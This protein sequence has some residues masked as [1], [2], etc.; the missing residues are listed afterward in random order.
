MLNAW[1][2]GGHVLRADRTAPVR[3]STMVLVGGT[4]QRFVV[5]LALFALG[6]GVFGLSPAPML[7]AFAFAQLAYALNRYVP[8]GT[9]S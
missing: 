1:F 2:L 4:A 3:A 5:T 9:N 6:M 7:S 8:Q